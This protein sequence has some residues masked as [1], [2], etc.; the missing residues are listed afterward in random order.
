MEDASRKLELRFGPENGKP[1]SVIFDDIIR[2]VKQ[3]VATMPN[4]APHVATTGTFRKPDDAEAPELQRVEDNIRERIERASAASEAAAKKREETGD[5]PEESLKAARNVVSAVQ[6]AILRG[7]A[8]RV[9]EP[10][11]PDA[12]S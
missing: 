6:R 7:I 10:A 2:L 4:D 5:Q 9:P 3:A 1:N 11:P 12:V 8:V